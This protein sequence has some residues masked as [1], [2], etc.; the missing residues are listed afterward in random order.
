[1]LFWAWWYDA[2]EEWFSN[3]E[4]FFRLTVSLQKSN[5]RNIMLVLFKNFCHEKQFD[6]PIVLV[7]YKTTTATKRIDIMGTC[8]HYLSSLATLI[9]FCKNRVRYPCCYCCVSPSKVGAEV[10]PFESGGDHLE[11]S[12]LVEYS[13]F[14]HE[15]ES[16]EKRSHFVRQLAQFDCCLCSRLPSMH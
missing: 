6:G 16:C 2:D 12:K 4:A 8:C 3:L 9:W 14:P 11:V 15:D 13:V 7:Y 5:I 1:M 10:D